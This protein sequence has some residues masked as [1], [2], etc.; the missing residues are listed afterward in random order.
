M[1]MR[2]FLFFYF[3]SLDN[4]HSRTADHEDHVCEAMW[5][6]QRS[7][8][9]VCGLEHGRVSVFLISLKAGGIGLNLT[10]ADVVIHYDP[11]WKPAVE[12]QATARAH[13][14]GQ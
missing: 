7:S 6:Y 1:G 9:S 12:N 5:R 13:R 10:A 3:F 2:K 8:H 11:W 4:A 14:L